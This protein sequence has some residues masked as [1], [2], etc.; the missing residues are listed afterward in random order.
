MA[1][2]F[3]ML[4]IANFEPAFA[5]LFGLLLKVMSA[6]PRFGPRITSGPMKSKAQVLEIFFY[7]RTGLIR[8]TTAP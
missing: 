2:R 3:S 7:T 8:L 6:S 5:S 4:R 1:P